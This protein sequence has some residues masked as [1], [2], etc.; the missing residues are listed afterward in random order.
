MPRRR[1]MVR[2]FDQQ[3]KNPARSIDSAVLR[4]DFFVISGVERGVKEVYVRADIKRGAVRGAIIRRDLAT[5]GTMARLLDAMVGAFAAFPT[6]ATVGPDVPKRVEY[7]TGII[8]DA[9]GRILTKRE[10]TQGCQVI[11]VAGWGNA[12]REAEDADLV[13]LHLYGARAL[14]PGRVA[15]AD[16][17]ADDVTLVG[18]ADLELQAGEATVT[19]TTACLGATAAG[20]ARPPRGWCRLHRCERFR[21]EPRHARTRSS[22]RA[23]ARPTSFQGRPSRTPVAA[24]S[25]TRQPT[26]CCALRAASVSSFCSCGLSTPV[27]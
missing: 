26:A 22:R 1:K 2:V 27:D 8:V 21:S 14:R 12:E 16:A 15:A 23:V 25:S 13:L 18:V 6:A 11:T 7:A 3:R 24:S 5:Q 17:G 4:P 19:A 9:A 20:A 10:T